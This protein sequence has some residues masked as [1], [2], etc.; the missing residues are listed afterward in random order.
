MNE[1]YT[2]NSEGRASLRRGAGCGDVANRL[3]ASHRRQ[4]AALTGRSVLLGLRGSPRKCIAHRSD[5]AS[6][7][8]SN[9]SPERTGVAGTLQGVV[10]RSTGLGDADGKH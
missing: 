9:I 6:L 10:G 8:I 3:A 7:C 4:I 1:R 2:G 5:L